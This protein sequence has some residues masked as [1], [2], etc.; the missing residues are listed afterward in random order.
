MENPI[1]STRPTTEKEE[2]VLAYLN[3]LRESGETNMFGAAPYIEAEFPGTSFRE[4]NVLLGLW[5][6]NFSE[7]GEYKT[8]TITKTK[9]NDKAKE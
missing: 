9:A 5:L 4:A 8:I 2:A 7:S 1:T 6:N 3:R